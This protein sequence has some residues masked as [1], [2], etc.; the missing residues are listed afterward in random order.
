MKKKILTA[1]F[2]IA[3]FASPMVITSVSAMGTPPDDKPKTEQ[4]KECTKDKKEC[5]TKAK[6][7]CAKSCSSD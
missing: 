1:V 7:G 5:D 4:K 6:E 2:S 3:L